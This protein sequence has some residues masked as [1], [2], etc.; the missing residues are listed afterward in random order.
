MNDRIR[1]YFDEIEVRL[2]ECPVVL[3]Y[4]ITRRDISPNIFTFT[5]EIERNLIS[6]QELDL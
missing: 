6:E 4:Q 2:F 5:D 3:A 1:S